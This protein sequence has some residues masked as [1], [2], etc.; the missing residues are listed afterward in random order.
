VLIPEDL[1]EFY[2]LCGGL[3][4]IVSCDEDLILSVVRPASFSWSLPSVFGEPLESTFPG[5][6]NTMFRYWYMLGRGDTD[7]FF[8]ID[9]N[10][11][12]YGRCYLSYLYYFGQ[13]GR[14]PIVAGSFSEFLVTLYD[15]AAKGERWSWDDI[16]LGDALDAQV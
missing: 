12:S 5:Y 7:E 1:L 11:A 8:V 10:P 4:S 3:E 2:K 6:E 9:L 16:G 14:T 15:A 13:P